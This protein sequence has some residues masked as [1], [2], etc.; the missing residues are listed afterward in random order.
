MS[1][2]VLCTGALVIIQTDSRNLT[3]IVGRSSRSTH[4]YDL[5]YT[6]REFC[7]K[8]SIVLEVNWVPR[9]LNKAADDIIKIHDVDDYMHIIP[10]IMRV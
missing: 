7:T 2:V 9:N 3:F 5:A 10:N 8:H 6:R 4:V 1:F